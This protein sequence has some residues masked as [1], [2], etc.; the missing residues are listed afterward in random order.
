MLKVL[1]CE[2]KWGKQSAVKCT[3]RSG[4]KHTLVIFW[5]RYRC[6]C[7]S[8]SLLPL[9]SLWTLI[10]PCLVSNTVV[11]ALGAKTKVR[12]YYGAI[13]NTPQLYKK[14]IATRLH[15]CLLQICVRVWQGGVNYALIHSHGAERRTAARANP[16]LQQNHPKNL[17]ICV[18]M[19]AFNI[20]S[21][22][23]SQYSFTHSITITAFPFQGRRG[24]RA[25]SS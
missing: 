23:H 22:K 11:L 10:Y 13:K 6:Q 15:H 8:S 12:L 14:K 4:P 16:E 24:T 18:F 25:N 1:F 7:F 19:F 9:F 17:P 2:S 5:G 21:V 3:V 20:I